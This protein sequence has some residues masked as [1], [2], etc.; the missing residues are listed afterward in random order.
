MLEQMQSGREEREELREELL[1]HLQEAKQHYMD[2]G[3][4]A[5]LAEKQA[6]AEFGNP[7]STGHQLQ[8]AMYPYQR[9]LL[10]VIG[11]GTILFGV[12]YF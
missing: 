10:Y 5:K 4:T 8:E 6:I 9:G 7:D 1:G 3:Y 2:E 12:L 11:I